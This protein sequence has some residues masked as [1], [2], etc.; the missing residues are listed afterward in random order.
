MICQVCGR[1]AAGDFETGYDADDV[2]PDCEAPCCWW[3]AGDLPREATSG[4]CDSA[5][6][7]RA[8]NDNDQ[9]AA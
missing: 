2:C 5:C 3:C 9:E 4:Y 7:A 6:E 8:A 1:W